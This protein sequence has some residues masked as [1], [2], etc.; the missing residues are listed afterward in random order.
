LGQRSRKRGQRQR[1]SV[2]SVAARTAAR[3]A[4]RPVAA[5]AAPKSRAQVR[6]AAAADAKPIS[7]AQVRDAAARDRLEPLAPGERPWPIK[8]GAFLA[9]LSG[10][11]NLIAYA[12]GTKIAGKHPSAGGIILFSG[13]MLAC[14]IGIWRLWYGAV[15][16]FMA[17]LAI[18]VVLFSLFLIEASNLLGFLVPPVFIGGAGFLFWKFVRVLGRIQMPEP[19]RR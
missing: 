4:A 13:L 16:A 11:G 2:D 15:L 6:D 17:L 1:P 18:I 9:A 12:A 5:D 14:A 7:R 8:I 3:T 10:I 19:P